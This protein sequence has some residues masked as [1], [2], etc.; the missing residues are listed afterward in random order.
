MALPDD[1]MPG[2]PHM[3]DDMYII[4]GMRGP[5]CEWCVDW[6][7]DENCYWCGFYHYEAKF[8]DPAD[9]RPH[10]PHAVERMAATIAEDAH[11]P[12]GASPEALWKT[13][14]WLVSK[15]EP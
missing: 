2:Q 4:D 1:M 8:D 9:N 6:W 14:E 13:S 15:W 5:L 11:V 7:L 12:R 3:D 10:R